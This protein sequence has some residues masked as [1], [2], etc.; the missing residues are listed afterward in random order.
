M[1]SITFD[2]DFQIDKLEAGIK[3]SEKTIDAWVM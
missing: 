2:A 1:S 3:K